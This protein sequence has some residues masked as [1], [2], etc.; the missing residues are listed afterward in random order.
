V[1]TPVLDAPVWWADCLFRDIARRSEGSRKDQDLTP[2]APIDDKR[3]DGTSLGRD[4][5]LERPPLP[6][7]GRSLRGSRKLETR[8]R[9]FDSFAG[10]ELWDKRYEGSKSSIDA[11][12]PTGSTF[13][14]GEVAA[15]VC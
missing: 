1:P 8:S 6:S 15:V 10:L 2:L 5:C 11:S 4:Q 7:K 9:R 3:V 14:R 13:P 12:I